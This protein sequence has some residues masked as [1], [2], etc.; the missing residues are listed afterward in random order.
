MKKTH[1]TASVLL[2]LGFGLV[3]YVVF[4]DNLSVAANRIVFHFR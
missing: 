1:V 2:L 3:C 4:K